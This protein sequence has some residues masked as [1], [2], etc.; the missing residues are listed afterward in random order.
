[1]RTRNVHG[2]PLAVIADCLRPSAPPIP[3]N[4]IWSGWTEMLS[5]HCYGELPAG[6]AHVDISWDL[7]PNGSRSIPDR[8]DTISSVSR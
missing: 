8:N 1:M 5:E 7:R 2:R 6:L 4:M 3:Y